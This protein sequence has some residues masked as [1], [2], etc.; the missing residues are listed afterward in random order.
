[1]LWKMQMREWAWAQVDLN[2]VADS[3]GVDSNNPN[4]VPGRF[5]QGRKAITASRALGTNKKLVKLYADRAGFTLVF[6]FD[7]SDSNKVGNN[8]QI[9]VLER[10]A[11]SDASVSLTKLAGKTIAFNAPDT[12]STYDMDT[13]QTFSSSVLDP[14]LLFSAVQSG[15]NHVAISSH[16][17]A[18]TKADEPFVERRC[19]F[20]CGRNQTSLRVDLTNVEDAFKTLKSKVAKDAIVWIGGCT[21]G[22]NNSFC[23]KAADA[24]GCHVVAA[25]MVLRARK[26]PKGNVDVLDRFCIPKVFAPGKM[27]PIT[28]A[29]FCAKQ[30]T[31]KF[32][33]PV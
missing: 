14:P 5:A 28:V 3:V 31:H 19:M 15:T 21:I 11:S 4:P 26:Y 8:L 16:G 6:A 24:S 20:V 2:D 23:Q 10:R 33:V 1:M 13:T 22:A 29:D 25:A 27:N 32:T 7:G 30:E 9:E 18:P 12:T 17:G